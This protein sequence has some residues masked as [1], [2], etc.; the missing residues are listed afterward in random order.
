M[1]SL[2]DSIPSPYQIFDQQVRYY[3]GYL[4]AMIPLLFT[5]IRLASWAGLRV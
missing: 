3:G 5:D 4:H 1:T 2:K